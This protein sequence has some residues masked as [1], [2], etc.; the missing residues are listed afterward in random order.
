MLLGRCWETIIQFTVRKCQLENYPHK[1]ICI[2]L[3]TCVQ[4]MR[5]YLDTAKKNIRATRKQLKNNMLTKD[6][7]LL[8]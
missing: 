6:S 3:H 1:I 8:S 7:K 5:R 2:H 4:M